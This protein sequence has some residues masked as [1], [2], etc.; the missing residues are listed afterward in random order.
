MEPK[1]P[2][3]FLFASK[4]AWHDG[5]MT[6]IKMKMSAIRVRDFKGGAFCFLELSKGDGFTFSICLWQNHLVHVFKLA[7]SLKSL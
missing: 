6:C 5:K 3:D 2:P 1:K 4:G 7:D